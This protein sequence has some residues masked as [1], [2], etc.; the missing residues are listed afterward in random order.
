MLAKQCWCLIKWPDYLAARVIK[1]RY[2]PTIDFLHVGSYVSRSFV[3]KSFLWGRELLEAG[4]RCRVEVKSSVSIYS[5]RWVPRPN[6]FKIQ[7]TSIFGSDATIRSVITPS[8]CWDIPRIRSVFSLEEVEAILSILLSAYQ[9]GDSLLWY[10]EKYGVYSIR[11]G[12]KLGKSIK[13]REVSSGSAMVAWW[14]SVWCI[15]VPLKVKIF[16]L[17]ACK[18]WLP[19]LI[20]LESRGV[21][22]GGLCPICCKLPESTVH[23]L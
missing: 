5:D 10:F 11:S 6:S 19:T 7:S 9:L 13:S 20:N 2:F 15:K 18:G 17:K 14:K 12:Y 3:W 23:A 8:N 22:T 16:L 21:S 1:D 4:S